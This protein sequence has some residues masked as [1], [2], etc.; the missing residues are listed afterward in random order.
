MPRK[1]ARSNPK[2]TS[3]PKNG[4]QLR[5]STPQPSVV[6]SSSTS[7]QPVEGVRPSRTSTANDPYETDYDDDDELPHTPL[8]LPGSSAE[9]TPP[10][11]ADT[12]IEPAEEDALPSPQVLPP[13]H[14][15]RKFQRVDSSVEPEFELISAVLAPKPEPD[16]LPEVPEATEERSVQQNAPFQLSHVSPGPPPPRVSLCYV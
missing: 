2:S 6:E 11:A 4:S 15:P 8:F 16:P 12:T 1:S 14:S 9:P 13:R 7:R 3:L 10:P 5:R